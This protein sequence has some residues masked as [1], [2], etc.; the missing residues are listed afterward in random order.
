MLPAQAQE[1][2]ISVRT[3]ADLPFH[4]MGRF[5][6]ALQVGQVRGGTAEGLSSK[7]FFERVRDLSL[8]L[9]AHGVGRGDRVAIMAESRPEWLQ[10]DLAALAAGAVTVPI[11]PTLSAGQA[12]YILQDCGA[13]FAIVPVARA[14]HRRPREPRDLPSVPGF[15]RAREA[16]LVE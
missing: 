12:R 8:G 7:A 6:K 11:Y 4:L 3:L 5:S 14:Q 13:R 2:E 9:Q 10:S 15:G 1:P 16:W